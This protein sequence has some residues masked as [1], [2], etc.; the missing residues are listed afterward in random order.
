M[1]I[2]IH[3]GKRELIRLFGI[4]CPE[5]DQDFEP[6]ASSLI[7]RWCLEKLSRFFRLEK[8]VIACPWPPFCSAL[9]LKRE[10]GP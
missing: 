2:V 4:D 5:K 9:S 7:Q 1:G 10:I 3:R 8:R 6:V